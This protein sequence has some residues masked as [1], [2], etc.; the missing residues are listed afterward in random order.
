MLGK[1]LYVGLNYV[2]EPFNVELQKCIEENKIRGRLYIDNPNRLI[3]YIAWQCAK[4]WL[5]PIWQTWKDELKKFCG[6]NFNSF[7][8]VVS[9]TYPGEWI[10]NRLTWNDLLSNIIKILNR[11]CK[12]EFYL[13][14]KTH[15]SD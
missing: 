14:L 7:K 1:D 11:E 13:E 2:P 3:D 9:F 8:H 15:L 5:T 4:Y 6:L 10:A 12:I